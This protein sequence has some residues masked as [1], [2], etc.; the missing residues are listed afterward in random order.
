MGIP[1]EFTLLVAIVGVMSLPTP[2][3]RPAFRTAVAL[4]TVAAHTDREIRPGKTGGRKA[5]GEEQRCRRCSHPPQRD[6]ATVHRLICICRALAT[7]AG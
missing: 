5:G 2:H 1:P 7:A 6:Y 3:F 4:A